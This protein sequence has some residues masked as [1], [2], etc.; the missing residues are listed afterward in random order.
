MV[1]SEVKPLSDMWGFSTC[2]LIC[3]NI[4]CISSSI[5][6]PSKNYSIK[7]LN[8]ISTL[9]QLSLGLSSIPWAPSTFQMSSVIIDFSSILHF[10]QSTMITFLDSICFSWPSI[11]DFISGLA[12]SVQPLM[13][14]LGNLHIKKLL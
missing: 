12:R 8:G 9:M 2:V 6:L 13:V 5:L 7:L 14:T 1:W 3:K 10:I 4:F 11:N